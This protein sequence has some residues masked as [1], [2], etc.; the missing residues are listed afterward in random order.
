MRK[1]QTS[2]G[3][4]PEIKHIVDTEGLNLSSFVEDQLEKYFSV[5]SIEDLDN[6]IVEHRTAIAALDAKRAVLIKAGVKEL[7]DEVVS[8]T[9]FERAFDVFKLR[10]DGPT[11]EAGARDWVKVSKA[12]DPL[13]RSGMQV[14]EITHKLLER[15]H[16][17]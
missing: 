17:V 8:E 4:T 15:Y 2:I 1:I 9:V 7:K 13:R 10:C 11:G 3:L 16:G 12:C 14:D 5:S 6:K